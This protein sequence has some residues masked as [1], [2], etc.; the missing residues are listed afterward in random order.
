V[1]YVVVTQQHYLRYF[2]DPQKYRREFKRY[3]WLLSRRCVLFHS[4]AERR[5][6]QVVDTQCEPP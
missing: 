6:I 3:D 4:R 1:R 2:N 5:E